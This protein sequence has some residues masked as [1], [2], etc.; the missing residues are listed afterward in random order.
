M[1]RGS[2]EKLT[3]SIIIKVIVKTFQNCATKQKGKK[4]KLN[5]GKVNLKI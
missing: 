1:S 3:N 4:L 2:K 5:E